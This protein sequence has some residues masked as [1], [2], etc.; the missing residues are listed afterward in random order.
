MCS[1]VPPTI[2]KKTK[3]SEENLTGKEGERTIIERDNRE[4]FA[5]AA[6]SLSCVG[7]KLFDVTVNS[8]FF[9]Q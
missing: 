6:E 2:T 3:S 7:F 1:E 5:A 8:A 4:E 9:R